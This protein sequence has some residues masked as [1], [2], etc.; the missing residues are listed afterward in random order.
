MKTVEI[1][2]A[3]NIV[4]IKIVRPEKHNALTIEMWKGLRAAFEAVAAD[5]SVR[6]V[7]LRGAG[8]RAF[9]VGADIGEFEQTRAGKPQAIAFAE[10]VH[11]CVRAI[12]DCPHP[13]I[14]AI[15]GLCVGGGVEIA[16]LAICA[17]PRAPVG[18]ACQY[19]GLVSRWTT[20][21]STAS[22]AS[23]APTMHSS[24]SMKGVSSGPARPW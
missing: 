15:E 24:S 19:S 4:T 22:S 6:V 10:V 17:L 11:D 18:L 5:G 12:Q 8:G 23:S 14:A 1:E 7:V 20:P 13:T 16:A 21:N 3:E 9:S 2:R